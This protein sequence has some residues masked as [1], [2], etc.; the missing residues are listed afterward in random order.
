MNT[1]L[2]KRKIRALIL[3]WIR[4]TAKG[5]LEQVLSLMA[6]DVVFLRPGQPPMRGRAAF[7]RQFRAAMSKVDFSGKAKIKEIEILGNYAYCWTHLSIAMKPSAGG[8][9]H[10]R[11]GNILSIYRREKNGEWVLFR[12]ANMV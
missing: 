6:R 12:D 7:A 1:S 4:A 5:D 11:K 10:R 8:T 3:R 9:R 2:E